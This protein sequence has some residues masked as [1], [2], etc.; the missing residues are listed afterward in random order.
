[1]ASEVQDPEKQKQKQKNKTKQKQKNKTKQK[2]LGPVLLV[3]HVFVHS[4]PR[5]DACWEPSAYGICPLSEV[6]RWGL[7]G[8]LYFGTWDLASYF[9]FP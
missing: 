9:M 6:F 8:L 3:G 7:I 1:M 5:W 4:R 2:L